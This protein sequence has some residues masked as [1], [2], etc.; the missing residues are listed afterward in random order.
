MVLFLKLITIAVAYQDY[1]TK[2]KEVGREGGQPRACA[3]AV[4]AGGVLRPMRLP[5][6]RVAGAGPRLLPLLH[7]LRALPAQ[8]FV[9]LPATPRAW[10]AHALLPLHHRPCPRAHSTCRAPQNQG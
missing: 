4:G 2:K 6:Q 1:S 5:P 3:A 9:S 10:L 8:G 7:G